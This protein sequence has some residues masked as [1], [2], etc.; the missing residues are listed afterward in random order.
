MP[1]LRSGGK[2]QTAFGGS[3][4]TK[5][6]LQ[7]SRSPCGLCCLLNLIEEV[8]LH[9]IVLS[10]LRELKIFGTGLFTDSRMIPLADNAFPAP[11]FHSHSDVSFVNTRT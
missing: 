2:K 11:H 1:H 5:K 9:C 8:D 6:V 3:P 10:K 7:L 4:K